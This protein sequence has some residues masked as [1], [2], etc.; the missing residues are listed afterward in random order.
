MFPQRS[1]YKSIVASHSAAPLGT[2]SVATEIILAQEAPMAYQITRTSLATA[3]LVLAV[4][5]S[6]NV[7]AATPR[8]QPG[9]R[10][11]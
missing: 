7:H 6:T 5:A 11:R 9:T 2:G 10:R 4:A 1:L 3:F 8:D